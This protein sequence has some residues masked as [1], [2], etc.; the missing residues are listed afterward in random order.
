[1]M[2][3]SNY[4]PVGGV[5]SCALY[6]ADAVVMALFS[7]EG[8]KIQLSGTPVE[9]TLLDDASKYDEESSLK[10]GVASI[11]HTLCLVAERGRADEWLNNAFVERAAFEG[12]V[13]VISMSDGRRLLAGYS[14]QLGDE[15]PLRLEKISSTSGVNLHDI[16]S[17]LLQLTS[18]D[19]DF[20]PEI[21]EIV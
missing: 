7:S 20:S 12:F 16:P 10:D 5:E 6:P 9:V 13:A 19:A 3:A 21:L 11:S 4:K 18:Q 1:M 14:V 8:C 15:Q 2:A 17:V